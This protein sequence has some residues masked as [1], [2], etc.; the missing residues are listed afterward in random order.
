MKIL[1]LRSNLVKVKKA[2]GMVENQ[3]LV[4][5]TIIMVSKFKL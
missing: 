2:T 5:T 1:L 4:I 3:K